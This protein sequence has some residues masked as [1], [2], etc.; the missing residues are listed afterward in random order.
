MA[1]SFA[2]P[3]AAQAPAGPDDPAAEARIGPYRGDLP[4]CADALVLAEIARKFWDR[5]R[6]YWDSGLSLEFFDAVRETGFRA[7]GASFIPRRHCAAAARFNDGAI[8][9]VIYTIGEDLGFI[10]FGWGVDWCVVG[11]DRSLAQAPACSAA[12][13]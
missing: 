5:E 2:L 4:A 7:R 6:D 13:P 10:G 1:C 3:A 9:Q 12:G 11:L 8:R